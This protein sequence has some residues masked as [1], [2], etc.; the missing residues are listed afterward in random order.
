MMLPRIIAVARPIFSLDSIRCGTKESEEVLRVDLYKK[1][2][3]ALE[4][5]QLKTD[6]EQPWARAHEEILEAVLQTPAARV[7]LALDHDGE[8]PWIGRA[9]RLVEA[10]MESALARAALR[11]ALESDK[12]MVKAELAVWLETLRE[13][14]QFG[15][16][17]GIYSYASSAPWIQFR[18]YMKEARGSGDLED[19]G[20]IRASLKIT[21][22]S[23][24]SDPP[25]TAKAN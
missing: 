17:M 16:E 12:E 21:P 18:Q 3:A 25:T 5:I 4:N 10:G 19:Y 11:C 2:H 6:I 15:D 9:K 13:L 8:Q 7:C 1:L 24:P 14:V 20:S 22:P 23:I